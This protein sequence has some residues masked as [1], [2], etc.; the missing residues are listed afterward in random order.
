M[1][2]VSKGCLDF[3][4]MEQTQMIGIIAA[5]QKEME[6][7]AE[8]MEDAV[9]EEA[10]GIRF[11]RGKIGGRD[12]VCAVCGIGKVFAAM[13]AEAMIIKYS[14]SLMINTGVGGTL[15]DKL[16]IGDV[17]VSS[18][19]CQHDMDT[20]A[21]GDEPG[22]VSGINRVYFEAEVDAAEKIEEIAE[23]MGIHTVRGTI[24]SGDRFVADK[25]TKERIVRLF[26]A[27]VCEM[28]GGAI[29]HVCFVCGVPFVVIR[30]VSDDADGG[31][32]EDYPAFAAASA[33]RSAALVCEFIKNQ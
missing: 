20:T 12:V 14:P 25:E 11:T 3:N 29:G 28:E 18:A 24:A 16:T 4:E 15:T 6:L 30:A 17:A 26:G 10:G 33:R 5:M 13:C 7:I 22:L 32:C 1:S 9:H 2:A 8:Q 27:V 23:K 31:A 21:L 19:V